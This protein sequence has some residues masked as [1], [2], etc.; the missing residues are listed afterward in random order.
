MN[1][2]DEAVCGGSVIL[3]G[4]NEIGDRHSVYRRPPPGVLHFDGH[5]KLLIQQVSRQLVSLNKVGIASFV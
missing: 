1:G 5:G 3:C 4:R 2:E